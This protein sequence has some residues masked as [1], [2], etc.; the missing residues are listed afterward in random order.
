MPVQNDFQ[1]IQHD[2][3][4]PWPTD[5]LVENNMID[6]ENQIY[7]LGG[8]ASL[9]NPNISQMISEER[10]YPLVVI[11]ALDQ[12]GHISASDYCFDLTPADFEQVFT[13]YRTHPRVTIDVV[14][15]MQRHFPEDRRQFSFLD[16][17][18]DMLNYQIPV[19]AMGSYRCLYKTSRH[20]FDE[21]I[22]RPVLFH[23]PLFFSPSFPANLPPP[24]QPFMGFHNIIRG[25]I[26]TTATSG[27][28]DQAWLR[29]HG[30]ARQWQNKFNPVFIQNGNLQ[31]F[32]TMV[33]QGPQQHTLPLQDGQAE[34]FLLWDTGE[35]MQNEDNYIFEDGGIL[36]GFMRLLLDRLNQH[37]VF[38]SG[39]LIFATL[40]IANVQSPFYFDLKLTP[41]AKGPF[42]QGAIHFT[43]FGKANP[44]RLNIRIVPDM[45]GVE[46]TEW[47]SF[48]YGP[49]LYNEYYQ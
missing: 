35:E 13:L 7:F 25:E 30:L 22:S 48:N 2:F 39:F 11:R 20:F 34:R 1:L 43:I 8:V 41:E 15:I 27:L 21:A 38:S 17:I 46:P 9:D 6:E 45:S 36:G 42:H 24:P 28:Y 12:Q 23:F 33:G 3:V 32:L 18:T 31:N 47:R 40:F 16:N 10:M 49:N 26:G 19:P 14:P 5:D 37:S 29:L 4:Q 44:N